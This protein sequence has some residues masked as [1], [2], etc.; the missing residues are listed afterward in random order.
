MVRVRVH[1]C[2]H[3]CLSVCF[4]RCVCVYRCAC[5]YRCVWVCVYSDGLRDV[6]S[7]GPSVG[8]GPVRVM[9]I[10]RLLL[11]LLN[12]PCVSVCVCMCVCPWSPICAP[13]PEQPGSYRW[14]DDWTTER[15]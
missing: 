1:L 7:R 3:L 12:L 15:D 4:Y 2:G 14:L 13:M 11:P 5:V 10:T 9:Q 8:A 6:V